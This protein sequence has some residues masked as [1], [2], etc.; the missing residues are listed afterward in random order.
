VIL[1]IED[2]EAPPSYVVTVGVRE[3]DFPANF[4]RVFTNDQGSTAYLDPHIRVWMPLPAPATCDRHVR[5]ARD[6]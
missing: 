6:D 1:W 2:P 4:W 3:T 5:Q